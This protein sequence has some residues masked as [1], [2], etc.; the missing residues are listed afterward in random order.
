LLPICVA[1]GRCVSSW[2]A[3]LLSGLLPTSTNETQHR[4]QL[5][6]QNKHKQSE[7]N[8]HI[9]ETTR[10]QKQKARVLTHQILVVVVVG[11]VDDPVAVLL[12]EAAETTRPE[13]FAVDS[14]TAL[15]TGLAQ[16]LV[17]TLCKRA[18]GD[19][20]VE[21]A[22]QPTVAETLEGCVRTPVREQVRSDWTLSTH[23]V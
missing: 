14:R 21:L 5:V 20:R 22:C 23:F 6:S 9:E 16:A 15:E 12:V 19:F 11:V 13:A 2:L 18:S 1:A 3:P 17:Q 10:A 4:T 7:K 8:K